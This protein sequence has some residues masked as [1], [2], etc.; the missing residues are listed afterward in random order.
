MERFFWV[1]AVPVEIQLP[2]YIFFC[3]LI[4]RYAQPTP[5]PGLLHPH[6]PSP[7]RTHSA[8]FPKRKYCQKQVTALKFQ[9]I[10]PSWTSF[11]ALLPISSLVYTVWK[12]FVHPFCSSQFRKV[13]HLK[14]KKDCK[15]SLWG[16]R[17]WGDQSKSF[18]W[19]LLW[20]CFSLFSYLS[21][22]LV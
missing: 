13:T 15:R 2:V 4:P 16:A 3:P 6:W 14:N 9:K 20:I 17:G 5:T 19:F 11:L 10:N 22:V 18:L 12:V 7:S 21:F 1:S 8:S